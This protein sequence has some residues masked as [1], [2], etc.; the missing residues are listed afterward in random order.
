MEGR[1]PLENSSMS[2]LA[3]EVALAATLRHGA[4]RAHAAIGFEAAAL[5]EDGFAGAFVDAGEEG[6]HHADAGAGGDGLGDVA[7]VLDASVGDDGDAARFCGAI[8]LG[9]GGDLG[10]AGA[11]DH[12]GGADGARADADFDGVRAGVDEGQGAFVGGDVAGEEV[13]FGEALFALGDGFEDAGLVAVGGVDGE[14]VDA[15]LDELGGA[16]EEVAGGADGTGDAQ[17]ALLILAGVGV[18]QLLLDVLDGDEALELVGVVDDEE[19]F[20]A[21]LVEDLLGLF[22]RGS[23]GD[24]D[25]VGLGHHVGDGDVGAGDEAEVAVGEDADELAALGDGDAGD[26]ETAHDVEGIGDGALGLDGDG[27]DDHAGLGALD[28]VDFAGLLLDG[29]VA[30]DDAEASLLGHGDGQARLGDGVHGG[31][32]ER[33]GEGDFRGQAGLGAGLAG[34]DVRVGGY[35]QHVVERERFGDLSRDHTS[36]L[37]HWSCADGEG[38]RAGRLNFCLV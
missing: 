24:G 18:L 30:V 27:V 32:H 6:T 9:D 13:D 2:S 21:M 1:S 19:L 36:L 34:N 35:Q 10:H 3:L 28:L 7:G 5:V 8:G 25:E 23:Y 14:G 29:E 26:L 37:L 17:A 20:D 16:F 11:G 4:E 15:I 31:G 38:L 33:G 12:A 22:E